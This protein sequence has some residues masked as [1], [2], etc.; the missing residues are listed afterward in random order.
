MEL[1]TRIE[2]GH[3]TIEGWDRVFSA[4][5]A[6]PRRQLVVSLLDAPADQSVPLPESAINPNVPGDP[7]EIRQE[8]Y[9]RHLPMLAD[10]GFIEWENDPFV[11]SRG[12]KFEEV[13]IVFEALY[14]VADDIPES[15]ILGCQ[16]LEKEQ[17]P[18]FK[19]NV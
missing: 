13:A 17:Q 19:E 11:A 2:N 15:L 10:K 14:S 3:R 9:H 5:T 4:I 12:P 1:D 16:R 8:L 6:E 7:D 18:G